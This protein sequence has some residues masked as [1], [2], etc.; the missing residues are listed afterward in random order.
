MYPQ[1]YVSGILANFVSQNFDRDDAVIRLGIS[2]NG[3]L[4]H[5]CIEQG[6]V[7]TP[8]KVGRLERPIEHYE[9]REVFHGRSHNP[10]LENMFKGTGWSS[11]AM[12]FAQ[13]Q[14]VLGHLQSNKKIQ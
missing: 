6:W 10:I 7:S 12:T 3:L 5:Y 8:I 4:P 11:V 2:G 9:Y 14:T 13:M 1:E